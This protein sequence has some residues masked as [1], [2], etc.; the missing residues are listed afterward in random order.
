MIEEAEK[1]G[2]QWAD[3]QDHRITRVGRFLRK[4]EL[5]NFLNSGISL[6]VK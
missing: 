5:M 4:Q 2:A 3:Q 1:K 6:L